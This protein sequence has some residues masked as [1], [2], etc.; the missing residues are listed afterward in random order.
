MAETDLSI[1]E[2]GAVEEEAETHLVVTINHHKFSHLTLHAMV[3]MRGIRQVL[4]M[5]LLIPIIH[6]LL[7]H[8]PWES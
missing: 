8:H 1:I 3:F 2:V 5:L 6:N 7:V 4:V